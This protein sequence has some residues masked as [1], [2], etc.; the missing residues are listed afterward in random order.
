MKW[1]PSLI[2]W[3]V[4]ITSS[5]LVHVARDWFFGY[6]RPQLGRK[7]SRWW[8]VENDN[9][10]DFP[11]TSLLKFCDSIFHGISNLLPPLT[12]VTQ[13][14]KKYCKRIGSRHKAQEIHLNYLFSANAFVIHPNI[15]FWRNENSPQSSRN[16]FKIFFTS[17]HFYDSPKLNSVKKQK[18][19][20]QSSRN[21]F[22]IFVLPQ[23]F[24]DSPKHFFFE[25]TRTR[26]K[27]LEI[28]LKYSSLLLTF[29]TH[30]NSIV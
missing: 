8:W 4:V 16:S 3:W 14:K 18:K 11:K 10:D 29:M 6:F 25:G 24:C 9:K 19:S 26:H 15:F 17:S 20:P 2:L 27:A 13:L 12:F 5:L 7:F 21:S 28:H 1:S 23:C 22:K 30:Q